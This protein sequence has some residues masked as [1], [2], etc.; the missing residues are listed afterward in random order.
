VV[1]AVEHRERE[2]VAQMLDDAAHRCAIEQVVELGVVRPGQRP[3]S[4]AVR[5]HEGVQKLGVHAVELLDEIAQVVRGL[6]IQKDPDVAVVHDEVGDRDAR[7]LVPLGQRLGEIRGDRG[8]A[9][10]ALAAV[11]RVDDP[12]LP[13]RVHPPHQPV[14]RRRQIL[15][16]GRIHQEFL[17]ARAHR[18]KD[19]VRFR[20]W[21]GTD[22]ERETSRTQHALDRR[23]L[24]RVE[25]LKRKNQQVVRL[26]L[27]LR[28][29]RADVE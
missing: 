4:L 13:V 23:E 27:K 16:I 29:R 2:V 5:R 9:Q 25:L 11:E 3:N 6:Q 8:R 24:Q 21:R 28:Q 15:G 26:V 20:A 17:D 1:L 19:E 7:V 12:A 22:R 14:E 18:A 10:P